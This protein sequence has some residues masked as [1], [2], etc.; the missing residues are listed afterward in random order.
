MC[1][2][3]KPLLTKRGLKFASALV[4]MALMLSGCASK[5]THP[6]PIA[7]RPARD[8]IGW[9]LQGKAAVTQKN[10]NSSTVNL[11]WSHPGITHDRIRLSGPLG[12][13]PLDLQREGDHLFWLNE[14]RREPLGSLRL[15]EDAQSIVALLPLDSVSAWLLG[16]PDSPAGWAVEITQWQVIEG[17]QVPRK[18]EAYRDDLSVRLVVLSWDF[19]TTHQ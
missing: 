3:K 12:T 14:G 15:N 9:S 13:S 11:A 17:W 19:E 6:D 2:W 1:C 8:H 10:Q 5:P 16:Y 7:Q 4:A 18:I